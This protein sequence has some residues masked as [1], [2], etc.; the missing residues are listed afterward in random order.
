MVYVGA[1]GDGG[2]GVHALGAMSGEVEWA[3]EVFYPYGA[4]F[5]LTVA[6]GRLYAPGESGEF[7]ALDA[8]T[9]ELLWS[10]QR[11]NGSRVP[12]HGPGWSGLSDGGQQRLRSWTR[13]TG[14]EIWSYGTEMFPARD[15]P[16]VVVDGVYYFAPDN[17]IYALDVATGSFAWYYP[18][19][20]LITDPPVVAEGMVFV[21]T[22]S[23]FLHALDAATGAP[24][25]SWEDTDSA[26]RS[27]AVVGGF[28]IAESADGNLRALIAATGQEIWSFNKG[29]FDG[30]PAYTIAGGVLYVGTL[31]GSVH[32]FAI[33]Q[34]GAMAQV[35]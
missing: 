18:L 2:Y 19:E 21:R 1:F 3:A 14:E 35:G 6:N 27:P 30:V 24:V 16:A 28:L 33:P 8:S 22:E 34:E 4:E 23:E 31:Q 32:A 11:R 20:S 13:Q 5:T 26:L 25:W 7:Y 29:Y 9:G 10:R 12:A 17:N 15:H